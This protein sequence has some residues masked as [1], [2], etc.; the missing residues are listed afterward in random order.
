MLE[1]PPSCNATPAA[2]RPYGNYKAPLARLC[3]DHRSS[4][5]GPASPFMRPSTKVNQ[6]CF[7]RQRV[8]GGTIGQILFDRFAR[9]EGFPRYCQRE[10]GRVDGLEEKRRP[11]WR[12]GPSGLPPARPV[13]RPM[14][15]LHTRPA[16]FLRKAPPLQS[17]GLCCVSLFSRPLCRVFMKDSRNNP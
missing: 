14:F 1:P 8:F 6:V 15:G 11:A 7:L 12:Q 16:A 17:P 3:P 13:W 4:A 10:P 5:R 9:G 2:N